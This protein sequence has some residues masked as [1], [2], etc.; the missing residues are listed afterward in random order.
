MKICRLHYHD[1]GVGFTM[2]I[3]VGIGLGRSLRTARR[4]ALLVSPKSK[5]VCSRTAT[6]ARDL[7]IVTMTKIAAFIIITAQTMI[8]AW[9]EIAEMTITVFMTIIAST[10]THVVMTTSETS[11]TTKLVVTVVFVKIIGTTAMFIAVTKTFYAIGI[12][13][14][15]ISS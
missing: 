6:M 1:I 4:F 2:E 7:P 12:G 11:R 10:T 9:E 3:V 8:D 13:V 5:I 15:T 14:I